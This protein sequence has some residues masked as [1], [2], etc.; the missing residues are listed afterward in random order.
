MVGAAREADVCVVGAGFAGLS[1]ARQLRQ[2]GR[3]V[4]VLEARDRVG[5]RIWTERLPDGTPVD[6]GGAWLAPQHDAAFALIGQLGVSTYRT[7]V[8]GHHLLVGEGRVRRYKGLIPKIS[9]LA[10]ATIAA[11]QLRID[12]LA[13][14]VPVEAPWEARRA[15]ELDSRTVASL[16]ERSGIRTAIGRDLFEMAVRGLFGADLDR[17]S[18]LHLLLLVHAHR[19]TSTLFSIEG[20]AQENLVVGGLGSVAERLA[21]SLD[22]ALC[23]S[24]PVRSIAQRDGAV[25]V[26]ADGLTVRCRDVVVAIPP[27][28]IADIEFEPALPEDRRTLYSSAMGGQET[29]TLLV[30]DTPFWREAGLSGQSA[31]PGSAA[32]VTIDASPADASRGVLA[33]F[34]FGA[35]AERADRLGPAERKGALLEVIGAR[36]GPKALVPEAMVET[37][38]W[39]ELWS[40][41]CSFAHLPPGMLTRYGRLL[42]E[43][44]GRVHWAG[45]ETATTSHGAVDGA[46]RSG[47][48][49]ATEILEAA[50]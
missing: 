7:W 8:A 12:R 44:M 17:V 38:W 10:V 18:L 14:K 22:D 13:K 29:K 35:V 3:S 26:G 23:L 37:S 27:A 5:G 16:L 25:V 39:Q 42:R 49:A 2:A 6:R 28:L 43:P 34:T 31:G 24:T 30:Y 46:I 50:G 15:E 20:G 48:R 41:G 40:K 33:S 32:E 11:A 21:A 1:A 45:T 4:L 36:F 9:P 19:N 47:E